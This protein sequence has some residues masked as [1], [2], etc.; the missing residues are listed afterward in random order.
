MSTSKPTK[1]PLY[2]LPDLKSALDEAIPPILTT[3]PAPHNFTQSHTHANIR[4]TLGYTAVL[5]AGALFYL[6]YRHGWAVTK[7]YTLP[8]VVVYF[9]LNGALTLYTWGVERHLIFDGRQSSAAGNQQQRLILRSYIEKPKPEYLLEISSSTG[10]KNPTSV[11]FA[12]LFNIHGYLQKKELR[13]WLAREI[14][15]VAL[16]DPASAKAVMEYE[17]EQAQ[18]MGVDMNAG[19]LEG[20]PEEAE[21]EAEGDVIEV[22]EPKTPRTG[23]GEGEGEEG[24]LSTARNTRGRSRTPEPGSG[25][26]SAAKRGPG[27]PK[28]GT[29]A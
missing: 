22:V 2:S 28:K 23:A 11:P 19:L 16:A 18:R 1:V 9:V 10:Q 21:G 27:R 4:L 12:V 5:I 26:S 20:A 17:R 29:K 13:K 14:E 3:L 6:D 24:G 8:A 15:A 25:A 7:P